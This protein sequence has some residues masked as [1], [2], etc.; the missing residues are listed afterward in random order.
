MYALEQVVAE[1]GIFRN[2]VLQTAFET[3]DLVGALTDIAALSEEILVD[4]RDSPGVKIQA[5]I[6]GKDTSE[7]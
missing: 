2:T 7:S 4:I 6:P 5:G 1:Q 3:V